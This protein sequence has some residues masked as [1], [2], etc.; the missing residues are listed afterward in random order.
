MSQATLEDVLRYLRQTC[1]APGTHDLTDGELLERFLAQREEAAF[2]ILVERHGP[3]V[4]N[5]CQRVLGNSHSAE[6]SFQ[7]TFLVLV[8][9]ASSIKRRGS[10]ASWLYGV[11]QRVASRARAQ[12]LARRNQER[13]TG[14]MR[15]A[16]SLDDLT[17]Q[18]LRTVLDEEISSLPEKYRAPIVLCY[19]EGKSYDQ[20]AQELGWPKSSLASR[21]SRA[22]GLLRD[23]LKRRGIALSA[24]LL[25]ATLT[26]EAAAAPVVA[27]L[28]LNT[29]KAAALFTSGK[30][31]SASVLSS[32]AVALAEE[33]MKGSLAMTGKLLGT[34]LALSLAVAAGLAMHSSQALSPLPKAGSAR[35]F[36][37]NSDE[38]KQEKPDEPAL[39]DQHGDSLP[40]GAVARL[41][42]MRFR[43]G[44]TTN[45]VAFSPGGRVLA[46]AGRVGFG[47]C[48]WDAATGRPLHRLSVPSSAF[49]LAFS[50]DGTLLVTD[51]LRLIEVAT[52]KELRRLSVPG[53]S[54]Y[55]SVAFSPDGRT[56]AAGEFAR[57]AGARII[58]WEAATGKELRRL[59][60][61]T[62]EVSSVVFATDGRILASGSRDKTVRL[63]D[64]ASGKERRRFEGHEKEVFAVALAAKGKLLASAGEDGVIL[65]DVAAA[66]PRHRLQR[67]EGYVS[68]VAFS[69][70]GKLLAAAGIAGTIHFWDA[71]TGKEVRQ[72]LAHTQ[73]ISSLAF[74]PDGKVLLS[75]GSWDHAIRRWDT[76]SGKEIDP[77]LDHTGAILALRFAPDGKALFS[78]GRDKKVLE[79][80]LARGGSG[81]QLFGGPHGPLQGGWFWSAYDLSLD[82]KVL[83]LAGY[84]IPEKKPDLVIRLC[85]LLTGKVLCGLSGH[86]GRVRAVRFSPD[87]QFLASAG[88]DGI[89]LWDQATGRELH[90]LQGHPLEVSAL[91][92]SPDGK[93]LASAGQDKT[94]RLW[95]VAIG[96]EKL[97]WDS[98]G[99]D[100]ETLVF[101]PDG[102]LLASTGRRSTLPAARVWAV[103]TGKELFR[104][105]GQ[106]GGSL[107]LVFS[108][109]GRIL[110]GARV[111]SR[112][113]PDENVEDICTIHLWEVLSGQ[114]VRQIEAPQGSVWSLA[115]APDGRTLASGGGDSTILLWDLTGQAEAG[116]RKQEPLNRQQ[117][118]GLW[119]VLGGDAAKADRA[120]WELARA[121][122]QS[123]PFL[124]ERLRLGALADTQQVAKL[125][126]DLDSEN[127]SVRE[128]AAHMLQEMDER[129]EEDLHKTLAG[130]PS[131]ETRRQIEQLLERRETE[132]V[133]K[134]RAIEVL[135]HSGTQ[136]ARHVLEEIA[137]EKVNPR[138]VQETVAV[139]NRLSMR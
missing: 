101:S 88:K 14:A 123:V 138:F 137:K 107:A 74:A 16:R 67:A 102:K 68:S 104:F 32:N 82:G 44:V 81:G 24:G 66:Q 8:R 3:M 112:R 34:L 25:A 69:P 130:N 49:S 63:W 77:L 80:D 78:C 106:D 135:E 33:A 38:G 76:S 65:W 115:F 22:R 4:L 122:Q 39:L 129:V 42:T 85:D 100:L 37:A 108:P 97:R 117:L 60:G 84:D 13:Q 73:G 86:E 125:V 26:Q 75:A 15:L 91:A 124:R 21:L 127:F 12:T 64:V 116:K 119:S 50:P 103:S 9:R 43:H 40:R 47:V 57:G 98:E 121:P 56:V 96:K 128:K 46:S 113:L 48:L 29:V 45:A 10:V 134:V 111:G 59:E 31:P 2:A 19:F 54:S 105:N 89:R 18:E 41:G 7:A 70:D 6:D 20:A 132:W 136:E 27:L 17:C 62:A 28:T 72:W 58:F 114:V 1:A 110:A 30:A 71:E 90:H 55:L 53:I 95:D 131:L 79:W 87:G 94:V 51:S 92:F 61:H 109:S 5:V 35:E 23:Q 11:A 126:T 83:A 36:A 133:R 118:D 99:E 52:G 120:L 93:L 139:L